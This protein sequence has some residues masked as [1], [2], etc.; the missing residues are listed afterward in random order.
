MTNFGEKIN[1]IWDIANL[2]RGPY[3]QERYGD[4]ILPMAVL[5]RFDCLL[6]D[7]KEEVL[8][9]AEE[10]EIDKILNRITGYNFNNTSVYDFDKL[11]DDPDNI[12]ENFRAYIRGF[13]PNIREIIENFDFDKEISKLDKNNLLYL[14]IKEFNKI[15]L[16]PEKVNNQEMG[17]IFEELIRRF[18]ENA[19]A[20]DHL[21]ALGGDG[22]GQGQQGGNTEEGGGRGDKTHRARLRSWAIRGD[23][24]W[25]TGRRVGAAW[26]S[27]CDDGR[28]GRR[29][30]RPGRP[31]G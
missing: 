5:R 30:R 11:L 7:S 19:E 27:G 18:S 10:V 13:T 16:H 9:K 31:A 22:G 21:H 12:A 4:V 15:D 28:R 17:Y 29:A 23:R 3:K 26:P 8:K 25:P 14:V 1:F 20:G 2:L 6:E 24:W